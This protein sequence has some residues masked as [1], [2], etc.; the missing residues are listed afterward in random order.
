M[1]QFVVI[2]LEVLR[3]LKDFLN[4]GI[5]RIAIVEYVWILSAQRVAVL[6]QFL[7]LPDITMYRMQIPA[8][9]HRS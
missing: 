5:D 1:T 9:H 3:N 7:R 4:I 2:I 8:D 6:D